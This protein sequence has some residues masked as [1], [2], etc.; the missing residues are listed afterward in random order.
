MLVLVAHL[1]AV[2]FWR[3]IL[4]LLNIGQPMNKAILESVFDRLSALKPHIKDWNLPK[5]TELAV[6]FSNLADSSILEA[7]ALLEDDSQWETAYIQW[8][9]AIL[10]LISNYLCWQDGYDEDIISPQ[11]DEPFLGDSLFEASRQL[12][13]LLLEME[14]ELKR[15]S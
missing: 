15:L 8:L 11:G 13:N 5:E 10:D 4:E 6:E 12:N 1:L 2:T 7:I 9:N 14:D 3:Q